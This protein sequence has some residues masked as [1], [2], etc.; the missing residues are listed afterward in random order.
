MSGE[1]GLPTKTS[2]KEI[3]CKLH[4]GPRPQKHLAEQHRKAIEGELAARHLLVVAEGGLHPDAVALSEWELDALPLPPEDHPD[5]YRIRMKRIEYE[6]DNAKIRAQFDKIMYQAWTEIYNTL[7]KSCA[8][9]HPTLHDEMYH[10]CRLDKRMDSTFVA[11]GY[12]D[13]PL[14]W[15]LY[16]K[17]LF[18]T[19]TRTRSD[20]GSRSSTC[21]Y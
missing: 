17:S 19:E 11:G 1:E 18:P 10:E 15:R 21:R 20:R 3:G 12:A 4:P 6:R 5:H 7:M 16:L 8:D 13:G 14:A 9:S 2:G